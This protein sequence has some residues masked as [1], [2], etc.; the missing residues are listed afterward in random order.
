MYNKSTH[1]FMI[2]CK[3]HK[4]STIGEFYIHMSD[5]FNITAGVNCL[6]FYICLTDEKT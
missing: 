5:Y 1:H 3:Y 6:F 2:I 4:K